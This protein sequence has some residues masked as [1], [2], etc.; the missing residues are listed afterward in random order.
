MNDIKKYLP[1]YTGCFVCGKKDKNPA[2]LNLR[3]ETTKNGVQVEFTPE[4]EQ[5]G[6][7]K[8]VHGGIISALL[9]ETIGWSVAVERK[10]LFITGELRVKFLKPLPVGLKIWVRGRPVEH[11]SR[12]SIA[13]GEIVDKDGTV[14]AKADGKFFPLPEEKARQI[15]AELTYEKDDIDVLDG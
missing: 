14:Y 9:D 7:H 15:N 4:K 12:Y 13:Q 6:Y 11:K 10:C 2:T 8:V 3:F 1:T 5:Q